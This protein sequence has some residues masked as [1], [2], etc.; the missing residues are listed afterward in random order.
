M[1]ASNGTFK[2]MIGNIARLAGLRGIRPLAH[3]LGHLGHDNALLMIGSVQLSKRHHELF[4]CWDHSRPERVLNMSNKI[5][6]C[7]KQDRLGC[8]P[9][10]AV[11]QVHSSAFQMH[12]SNHNFAVGT[13]EQ[14]ISKPTC[15]IEPDLCI[16]GPYTLAQSAR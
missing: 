12:S 10:P 15:M 3:L 8:I 5:Y 11:S 6:F 2:A 9:L 16:I 13:R 7:G 1:D 4:P 14:K